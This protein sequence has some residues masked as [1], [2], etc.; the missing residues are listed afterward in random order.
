MN[1]KISEMDTQLKNLFPGP[2]KKGVSEIFGEPALNPVLLRLLPAHITAGQ[3]QEAAGLTE[4]LTSKETIIYNGY[5]LNKRRAEYLTGRICAKI[6]VQSFLSQAKIH[7]SPLLLPEIEIANAENGRPTV[8]LLGQKTDSLRMDISISHSGNYGVAIAAGS[9][10]GIDLQ[11]QK[12]TLLQVQEKY[13]HATE[14]RLLE[15]SLPNYGVLTRQTILWAAKEAGK[16]ALSDW[17]MPGFL[18]LEMCSLQKF[19]D[20]TALSLRVNNTRHTLLPS[21]VTVATGI[22]ED[23][24]L[25]I[26][27]VCEEAGNART[28]RS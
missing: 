28:S 15:A 19:P 6:A 18:D 16:K 8:H 13:C 9:R 12:A 20:Y 24:A 10:C 22:F 25:A 23:Y 1:T 14:Y 7:P 2:F 3:L 21:E 17:Q 26:C 4:Q 11:M 27:L 5:S